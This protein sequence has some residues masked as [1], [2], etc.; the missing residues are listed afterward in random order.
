MDRQAIIDRLL[1]H[2]ERPRHHG[3]LANAN[4]VMPGGVPDCGDTITIYLQVDPAQDR[5]AG[6]SFEGRGC[7]ISQAAASLLA[8]ELQGATLATIET[9]DDGVLLDLIGREVARSRPR[10]ATLALNT[11]K[12]AIIAYRRQSGR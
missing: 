6:L 9:M 10:C 2:Y 11:L 1:D 5:V 3:A 12:A 8:E 4:V 7:T